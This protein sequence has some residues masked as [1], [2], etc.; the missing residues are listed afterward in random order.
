MFRL[1]TTTTS[2]STD[3]TPGCCS[4]QRRASLSPPILMRCWMWQLWARYTDWRSAR[5][6]ASV[7]T[8]VILNKASSAFL[9]SFTYRQYTQH[10]KTWRWAS[11]RD[12]SAESLLACCAHHQ[13][14]DPSQKTLN[15]WPLFLS[16]SHFVDIVH[17]TPFRSDHYSALTTL[18]PWH[19][20]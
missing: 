3:F 15:G 19:Y 14:I 13:G 5:S 8:S 20:A 11:T 4:P 9:I 16:T 7:V 18:S 17:P 10:V 1:L 12:S 6:R 2:I